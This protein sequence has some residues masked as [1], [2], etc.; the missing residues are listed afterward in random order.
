MDKIEFLILKNLYNLELFLEVDSSQ[1]IQ[2]S[3]Y[4]NQVLFHKLA[5][6]YHANFHQK[7]D[8]YIFFAKYKRSVGLTVSFFC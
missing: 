6:I 5:L 7:G 2:K 4:A 1:L 8:N 3:M